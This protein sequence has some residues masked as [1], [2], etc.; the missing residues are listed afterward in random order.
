MKNFIYPKA[1]PLNFM[2]LKKQ[3]YKKSKIIIFPVHYSLTNYWKTGTKEGPRAII[4]ASRYIEFYDIETKKNL[5][6]KGIFTLEPLEIIT[7][8]PKEVIF[9]IKKVIDKILEDKKFPL[10]LGGEHT[11][12]LGAILSFK[13]RFSNLSILQIDAHADLGDEYEGSKYHRGCVMRRIRELNIPLTQVGIRS[14]SEDEVEYIEKEGIKTIFYAPNLPINKIISTLKRDV[15]LS[16]DL[17]ALDP[18]IMPSSSTPEP[19]GLGWYET[20]ELIKEVARKKKI[21]GADVVELDPIPGFIAPDLL[22][23][24]LVYKIISY[25]T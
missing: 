12:T 19:G 16:F 2:G 20:L 5:S 24:K 23:A 9:H 8:S 21:V 4:E 15:Y 6:K 1:E 13:E 11:I 10:M 25:V 3:D 17:D 22:A 14:I 7:N 18:A